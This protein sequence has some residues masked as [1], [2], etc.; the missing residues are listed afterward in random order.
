LSAPHDLCR[1]RVV[2]WDGRL[3]HPKIAKQ[4]GPSHSAS[5]SLWELFG[6]C[7]TPIC[8][9]SVCLKSATQRF[10]N[11]RRSVTT[12]REKPSVAF[13][14]N[15]V[16]VGTALL[17]MLYLASFGPA[18]CL[19][20][21]GVLSANEISAAYLPISHVMVDGPPLLRD[22]ILGYASICGG[23]EAATEVFLASIE[24]EAHYSD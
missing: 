19:A 2:I 20:D 8:R 15:V 22:A 21:K 6:D 1:R 5:D 16:V 4:R 3:S 24:F 17:P 13:W 12:D 18:C 10:D 23:A 9:R 14:A 11:T 7:R